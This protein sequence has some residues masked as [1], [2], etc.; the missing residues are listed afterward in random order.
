MRRRAAKRAA[1]ALF[2]MAAVSQTW[3]GSPSAQ[4]R[5]SGDAEQAAELVAYGPHTLTGRAGATRYT[6]PEADTKGRKRRPKMRTERVYAPNEVIYLLPWTDL[7]AAAVAKGNGSV[8]LTRSYLMAEGGEATR[9]NARTLTRE[10]GTFRIRGLKPG[11]YVIL[12]EVS[13]K[14]AVIVRSDTGRTRTETSTQG[15]PVF[16]GGQQIGFVPTS[17]TSVTSPIYRYDRAVSDLKHYILKVV[18]VR[19]DVPVTEL[20]EIE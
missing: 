1:A 6:L 3:S 9:L 2:A 7:V 16:Q 5:V 4:P 20:G 18:D 15:F 19:A 17:S 12:T 13:Y 8:P 14:A 10:D 11:R